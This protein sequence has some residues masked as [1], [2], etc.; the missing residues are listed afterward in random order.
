MSAKP[1]AVH[2]SIFD[3]GSDLK[4]TRNYLGNKTYVVNVGD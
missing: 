4:I 3:A 1:W 2:V